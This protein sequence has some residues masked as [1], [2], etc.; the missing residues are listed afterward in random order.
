M[1]ILLWALGCAGGPGASTPPT[2]VTGTA[3]TGS[4]TSTGTGS[5]T[6][7]ACAGSDD[8]ALSFGVTPHASSAHAVDLALDLVEPLPA[9]WTCTRDADP[10]EVHVMALPASATHRATLHGLLAD[11]ALT[12]TVDHCQ[13]GD[14]FRATV[15][16]NS[17]ASDLPQGTVTT[18]AGTTLTGAYTLFNHVGFCDS[19]Q[20][21]R[22]VLVDPEGRIRW[23]YEGIDPVFGVGVSSTYLGGGQFGMAGGGD[24]TA[25]P[26]VVDLEGRV[27]TAT[28]ASLGL[29]FH[30]HAEPQADG[31]WL[32]LAEV[33]NSDGALSW[34][35]FSFVHHDPT[36]DAVLQTWSSEGAARDGLLA[37]GEG[38][39]DDPYH[40]NWVGQIAGE[41]GAPRWYASLCVAQQLIKVDPASGRVDWV[42]GRD[43]SW[44]LVDPSGSPLPDDDWF[45][46]QH[47]VDLLA[48][49][50]FVLY[51]NG[52]ERL[53]ARAT[54]YQVDP[55]SRTVT[56]RWTWTETDWYE[57]AWGD[58]DELGGG[59]VLVAVGH[60]DCCN[61][62]RDHTTRISEVDRA[63]GE[64]VWR[65]ALPADQTVL[66]Q[67]TRVAGC[68]LFHNRKYC[69][70]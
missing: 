55:A 3:T 35:G 50:R 21:H 13:G 23:T 66:Y 11:D 49:D 70:Q 41:D 18:A 1:L 32:S 15:R 56:R 64:V 28:P 42:I 47:G 51:D 12:C 31:T 8:G 59:R 63:S 68:D 24:P 54:E 19:L 69:P 58:V 61:P 20:E 2:G 30:H 65:Y 25:G 45:Q 22:L 14:P 34:T 33:T 26:R 38:P 40:A 43:T 67:A 36:T 46:C 16:T 6:E 60:C 27:V 44:Q 57:Q 17:G 48:D 10:T 62:P 39:G 9:T 4:T 29:T 52:R 5:T 37:K 7:D 53:Q